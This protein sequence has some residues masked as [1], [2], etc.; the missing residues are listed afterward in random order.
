MRLMRGRFIFTLALFLFGAF[1]LRAHAEQK[2]ENIK[3]LEFVLNGEISSPQCS[4]TERA[5]AKA[6]EAGAN[7]LLVNMDTPGGDLESTLKIMELLSNSGLRTI[8]YVNPNAVS[9]GSYIATSCDEI[10]FAPKGV[11][12]AAE[13]VSASGDDIGESMKRKLDSFMSAKVKAISQNSASPNPNVAKVQRAMANPD[14]ELKIGDK[15][16]KNSG[17]LLSLTAQEAVEKCDGFP[18][19][20]NGIASDTLELLK[21]AYP[22]AK[23]V[24]I[25]KMDLSAFEKIA[26]YIAKFSPVIMGIALLFFFLE[27]KTAGFGVFGIIF[28]ALMALVFFGVNAAGLAG[29]EIPIIFGTGVL[30]LVIEFSLLPGTFIFGALGII[31]ISISLVMVGAAPIPTGG[32]SDILNALALGVGKF[33][34]ALIIAFTL[35]YFLRP[36]I[37][38]T[39]LWKRL[40]L[41]GGQPDELANF[42]DGGLVGK[43]GAAI[44]DLMPNGKVSVDGQIYDA[45]S[46]DGTCIVKGTPVEVAKFESFALRVR[47]LEK[48]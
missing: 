36:L 9:A 2:F 12:G 17:E 10:W 7:V 6:K 3:A 43:R 15:L 39:P 32:F 38:S 8:C 14:M 27:L 41:E 16:I 28:I 1:T 20:A 24:E 35:L 13:A 45:A 34:I 44:S 18:L 48:N 23:S 30:M 5:V 31:L 21:K 47:R 25:E 40:V 33:S 42:S 22:Y 37:K 29:Y 19:L 11:M 26:K 46:D 4:I